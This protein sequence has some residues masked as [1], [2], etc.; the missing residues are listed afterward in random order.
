MVDAE[1]APSGGRGAPGATPRRHA[2]G[3]GAGDFV[4]SAAD[5]EANE[6]ELTNTLCLHGGATLQRWPAASSR[7]LWSPRLASSRSRFGGAEGISGG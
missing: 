6:E 1:C 7:V 2:D 4:F 5:P 3:S